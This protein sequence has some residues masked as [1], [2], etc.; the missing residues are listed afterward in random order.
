MDPAE[1]SLAEYMESRRI[2][3]VDTVESEIENIDGGQQGDAVPQGGASAGVPEN[4]D[5]AGV[6]PENVEQDTDAHTD[7]P[8]NVEQQGGGDGDGEQEL[9]DRQEDVSGQAQRRGPGPSIPPRSLAN[10]TP[11]LPTTPHPGSLPPITHLNLAE[12]AYTTF[13]EYETARMRA[14][15][16]LRMPAPVVEILAPKELRSDPVY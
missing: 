7:P 10:P 11:P 4:E 8:E 1:E 2:K 14:F 6:D 13:G 9:G 12:K 5:S 16:H 15:A 3:L